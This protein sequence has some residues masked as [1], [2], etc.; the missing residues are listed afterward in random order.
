LPITYTIDPKTHVVMETWT[1]A[2]TAKALGTHWRTC[3]SDPVFLETGKSLVDVRQCTLEFNGKELN[4]LV[5]SIAAPMLEERRWTTALIVS[6]PVH[7]G[8]A[9]QYEVFSE[10]FGTDA[11][12]DNYDS[13]L[14]WILKQD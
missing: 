1:G 6:S 10:S 9:R 12:F 3:L 13:A 2:I 14:A 8:T 7:Y 11:I 5:M 4:D